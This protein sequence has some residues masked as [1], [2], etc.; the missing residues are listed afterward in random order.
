M[1]DLN[2]FPI[3]KSCQ[4]SLKNT[5]IDSNNGMY[6]IDNEK[7]VVD[8]DEVKTRY[9]KSL[10]LRNHYASSVDALFVKSEKLVFIEFKNGNFNNNEIKAKIK[11]SLL[12]FSDITKI[13]ISELRE[14]AA[15]I[16]VISNESYGKLRPQDKKALAMARNASVDFAIYGLD[17]IR[18]YLFER[19]DCLSAEAFNNWMKK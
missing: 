16:L 17:Y 9:L 2:S 5:S 14:N 4:T 1:I 18:R 7:V 3:F 12:I 13:T 8:F 10:K 6:L 19:V 15:F 11:D